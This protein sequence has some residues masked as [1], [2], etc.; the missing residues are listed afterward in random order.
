MSGN[1][2]ASAEVLTRSRERGERRLKISKNDYLGDDVF[3]VAADMLCLSMI[4]CPGAGV[5]C[6]AK[7]ALPNPPWR[8]ETQA[9]PFRD[10]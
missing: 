5:V 6:H 2:N 7:T 1:L 3:M 9:R 10:S 4:P 8:R